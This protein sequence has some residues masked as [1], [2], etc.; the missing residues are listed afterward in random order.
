MEVTYEGT[1]SGVNK[2]Y[3][4][5][6]D[7]DRLIATLNDLNQRNV[8]YLLSYHGCCG[9]TTYGSPLPEE[10]HLTRLELVAGR[11]SQATLS[12]RSEI[13]V[14]SLYVS[15]NLTTYV[16]PPDL[17]QLPNHNIY[18]TQLYGRGSTA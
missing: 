6:V 9:T 2:R 1:S 11:S 3:Y 4:K 12:G 15:R 13:T 16:F 8:P 5:G 7:R 14:E 18:E 10:L 17:V